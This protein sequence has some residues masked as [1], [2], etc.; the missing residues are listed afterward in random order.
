LKPPPPL[1]GVVDGTAPT[2]EA[3]TAA[4][5][6]E[7]V[8]LVALEEGVLTIELPVLPP[9]VLGVLVAPPTPGFWVRSTSWEPSAIGP[10]GFAGH[11]PAGLRGA[12]MPKGIVPAPPTAVPPT[13]V[14][15]LSPW[16][17]HWKSPL[18]SALRGADWQ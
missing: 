14:F 10:E 15:G 5:A 8:E 17:W 9:V 2:G 12:F 18:S 6:A 13:K 7:G 11:E 16:N 4:T 1:A 3:A